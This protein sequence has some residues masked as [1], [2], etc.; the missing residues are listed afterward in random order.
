MDAY[1]IYVNALLYINSMILLFAQYENRLFTT[2]YL[3]L[4]K[5]YVYYSGYFVKSNTGY[6]LNYLSPFFQI[7]GKYSSNIN[8]L[9]GADYDSV[10]KKVCLTYGICDTTSFQQNID[11]N[12]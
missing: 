5:I 3:S 1:Y 9:T 8:Y 2:L 10:N 11:K 7:Q 4:T 6:V 12:T